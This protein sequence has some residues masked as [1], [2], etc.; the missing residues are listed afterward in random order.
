MSLLALIS[1]VKFKFP[2]PKEYWKILKL[3][4]F[5]IWSKIFIPKIVT[6]K[7]KVANNAERVTDT[8]QTIPD[9]SQK[10]SLIQKDFLL[11]F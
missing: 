8:L 11:D 10:T 5:K 2:S 1:K 3:N 7:K 4:F 6:I 9:N